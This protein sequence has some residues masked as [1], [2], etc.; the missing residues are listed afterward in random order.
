[1]KEIKINNIVA[2]NEEIK[3]YTKIPDI[4]TKTTTRG[5][6]LSYNSIVFD[7]FAEYD[8]LRKYMRISI[9]YMTSERDIKVSMMDRLV[10]E[11]PV[12]RAKL[13]ISQDELASM[14][15]ISRQTYSTIE[16]RKSNLS[17][18]MFLAL[19]LI[20]ENNTQT[21]RILQS[22]GITA[23]N[24]GISSGQP[25]SVRENEVRVEIAEQDYGG[26]ASGGQPEWRTENRIRGGTEHEADNTCGKPPR[27]VLTIAAKHYKA[28][29]AVATIRIP[30]DML[31]D[32]D[33]VAEKSGRSRNDVITKMF[34]FAL[35]ELSVI[36]KEGK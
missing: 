25:G 26:L 34:E 22:I 31:Q 20:F 30:K 2:K 10:D 27:K 21:R 32:I 18:S 9:N 5:I 3:F 17:W 13:E 6:I 11:L 1:M 24:I 12:L 33:L 15:G 36:D 8:A 35:E 4:L 23:D 14:L 29:S 28:E 7:I 19:I 16:T